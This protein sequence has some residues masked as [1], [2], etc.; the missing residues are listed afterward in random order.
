[1]QICTQ[2]TFTELTQELYLERWS[3]PKTQKS[4]DCAVRQLRHYI[5]VDAY[6]EEVTRR[7]VLLWRRSIVR[8]EDVPSGIAE[9]SWNTYTRHLRSLYNFG[10]SRRYIGIGDNPFDGMFLREQKHRPKVLP[11]G[12]MRRLREALDTCKRFERLRQETAPIHPAWFWEIVVETFYWTGVRLN[13]LLAITPADVDLRR[14]TIRAVAGGAKNR[15]ENLLPIPRPLYPHIS[16]LMAAAQLAGFKHNDQLFN[17]NRFSV[18]HRRGTMDTNQIEHFFQ[19]IS[20][21][22]LSSTGNLRATP[23]RFRHS[24][25]TELMQSQERDLPLTKAICGHTDIRSTLI[26][27]HPDLEGM[28]NYMENRIE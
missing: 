24:M 8:S 7:E 9:T 4:Y 14:R 10:I 27:V 22:S 1:M 25:A 6:P 5:G 12:A 28:R 26:Y 21:F 15:I 19:R 3:S 17:V 23:H 16:T 13:Q 11:E 18:R 2:L 20:E